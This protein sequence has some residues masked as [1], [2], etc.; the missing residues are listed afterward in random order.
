MSG[1]RQKKRSK[2]GQVNVFPKSDDQ[3]LKHADL[4]SDVQKQMFSIFNIPQDYFSCNNREALR[5]Q[6]V[7]MAHA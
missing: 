5:E 4:K 7:S 2:S 1:F 3:H 6:S